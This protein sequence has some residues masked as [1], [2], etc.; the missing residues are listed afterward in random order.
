MFADRLKEIR[1]EKGLTQVQLAEALG[2]SKGTVAMWET[3]KR[4]PNYETLNQLS[5]IFDKRIDYIL[6]YSMDASSP[7]LNEDEEEQLGKWAAEENFQET[8][9]SFLTLDAYGKEAVESLIR[10][11]L[12][13][14]KNQET[15]FPKSNF[16]VSIRLK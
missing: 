7:K 15:L 10:V 4:T 12:E 6:G 9:T 16:A 3:S 2:V 14:C 8:I 11:E 5:D 1:G 13:R